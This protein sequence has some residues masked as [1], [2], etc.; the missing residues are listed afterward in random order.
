MVGKSLGIEKQ[1]ENVIKSLREAV[2][3]NGLIAKW[4]ITVISFEICFEDI[5]RS[6]FRKGG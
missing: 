4:Y 2:V 6:G 1:F 3:V 5:A